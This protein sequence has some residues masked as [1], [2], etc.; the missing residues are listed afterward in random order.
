MFEINQYD[1]KL[2][3][4]PPANPESSYSPADEFDRMSLLF[5]GEHCTECAA[6]ACYKSC[7]LYQPRRD[8]R[9]RRFRFGVYK[10]SNFRSLRGYGAEIEFKKWG[11]IFTAGNTAVE[12][13]S[14]VIWKERLIPYAAR[15][16]NAV[17]PL[18]RRVTHD[19]RWTWPAL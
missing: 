13:V 3:E 10:N 8:G 14:K 2:Q 7:D 6:P 16:A 15:M 4:E 19:D 11:R 1:R 5:W 17:G 12:P 18:I 9:C